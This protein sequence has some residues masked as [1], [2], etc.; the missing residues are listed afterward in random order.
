MAVLR[1]GGDESIIVGTAMYQF[2]DDVCYNA[3]G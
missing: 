3:K 2:D 1:G